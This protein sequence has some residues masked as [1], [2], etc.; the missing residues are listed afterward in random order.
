MEKLFFRSFAAKNKPFWTKNGK[1][2]MLKASYT[3]KILVKKIFT[4]NLYQTM[5]KKNLCMP[6][7]PCY[8]DY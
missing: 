1:Y 8:L 4:E 6:I 5:I 2:T 7:F 3:K